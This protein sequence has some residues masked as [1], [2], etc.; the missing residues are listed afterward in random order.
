M[1]RKKQWGGK[2][3]R[4]NQQWIGR[5][6]SAARLAC[7]GLFRPFRRLVSA[8]GGEAAELAPEPARH[9]ASRPSLR[10]ERGEKRTSAEPEPARNCRLSGR[11]ERGESA[12]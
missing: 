8:S 3:V 1:G 5:E 7:L 12:A 2:K 4:Q 11:P 9:V 6:L 10:A